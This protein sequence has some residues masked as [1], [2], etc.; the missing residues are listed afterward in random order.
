MPRGSATIGITTFNRPTYCTALLEQLASDEIDGYVDEV[1]VIDRD[2]RGPR[3]RG[4]PRG[5]RAAGVDAASRGAAQSRR[6]G[7]VLARDARDARRRPELL[8]PA[9]RRRRR[10]RAGG[11]R[12]GGCLR[13]PRQAADHRRWPHVQHVPALGPAR[14]RRG[15]HPVAVPLGRSRSH[16]TRPRPRLQPPVHPVAPPAHGR[17]LQRLVD[18]P[19]PG[20]RPS[21]HRPVAPVVHQVG[22][23][24]VRTA[25]RGRGVPDGALPGAAVCTSRG[26]TRTTAWTGRRTSMPATASSPRCCTRPSP[27]AAGWC[28]RA[29]R[30]RSSTCWGCSTP[31]QP[32]GSRHCAT[33]W[34]GRNGC[35]RSCR[36]SWRRSGLRGPPTR[37]PAARPRGVRRCS[38]GTPPQARPAHG[39]PCRPAGHRHRCRGRLGA[40]GAAGA[41]LVR[42]AP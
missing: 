38:P 29:W 9:A 13:R 30:S 19:D 15:R 17:G 31:R 4:I 18:V 14:L 36:T 39:A 6:L 16:A 12:A 3:R 40:P 5:G 33:C 28:A 24:R 8:R 34:R 41:G 20:R 35:T 7:R 10:L 42:R 2:V 22:R 23:R 26:R 1:L 37:T 27:S 11:D 32:C 21:R 25:R